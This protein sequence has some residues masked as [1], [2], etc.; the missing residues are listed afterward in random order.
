MNGNATNAASQKAISIIA[1]SLRRID[2]SRMQ[3]HVN[4]IF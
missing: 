2:V 4:K 3:L 1:D